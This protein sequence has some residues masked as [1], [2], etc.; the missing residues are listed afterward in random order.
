M[1]GETARVRAVG[2]HDVNL[3]VAVAIRVVGDLAAVRR[4][5]RRALAGVRRLDERTPAGPVRVHH[6][7]IRFAVGLFRIEGDLAAV[8]RPARGALTMCG[9]AAVEP[10]ERRKDYDDDS[11]AGDSEPAPG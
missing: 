8:G 2:A 3:E 5:R 11:P 10:P 7:Q 6:E 9:F 1:R 4:K